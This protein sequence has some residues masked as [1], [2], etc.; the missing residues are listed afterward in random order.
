MSSDLKTAVLERQTFF[1][2]HNRNFEKE[3]LAIGVHMT[4]L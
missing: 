2:I 3:I 4:I 1:M